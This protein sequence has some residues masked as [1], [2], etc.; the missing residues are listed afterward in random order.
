MAVITGQAD[1]IRQDE[2]VK[3]F[4]LEAVRPVMEQLGKEIALCLRYCSVTF[5]GLRSDTVTAVGGN[6]SDGDLLQMLSD[7]VDVP[8]RVGRPMRNIVVENDLD[9]ADRRTGLPEWAMALGLALKPVTQT[10]EVAA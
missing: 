3:R 4:V 2:R 5:R 10:A 8:F 1:R 7:H 9:G 6:A